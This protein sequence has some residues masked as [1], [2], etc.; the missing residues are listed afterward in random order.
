[1]N[2]LN[3]TLLRKH[4][5]TG[6]LPLII[7]K[8]KFPLKLR[9][10]CK[11]YSTILF[12]SRFLNTYFAVEVRI[13]LDASQHR[14]PSCCFLF[15]HK[16]IVGSYSQLLKFSTKFQS[17]PKL[18]EQYLQISPEEGE[19]LCQNSGWVNFP[20][21]LN[22]EFSNNFSTAGFPFISY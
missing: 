10:K 21:S 12:D 11:T 19:I 22:E 18:N 7:W 15:R 1:M 5:E 8:K 17:P 20:I 16:G 13:P 6:L 2:C 14:W 3:K 4:L 9:E